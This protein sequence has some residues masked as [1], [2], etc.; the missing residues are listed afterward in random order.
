MSEQFK[1]CK[2]CQKEMTV[3]DDHSECFRHQTCNEAFPC[4]V[5]RKW[6]KEKRSII[7]KMIDKKIA[8][9]TAASTLTSTS[10]AVDKSPADPIDGISGQSRK[11]PARVSSVPTHSAIDGG[12]DRVRRS[13][14][15]P[16]IRTVTGI[17]NQ[18]KI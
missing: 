6:S 18:Q 17:S 3:L 1:L 9:M 5:C 10:N 14:I 12:G 7:N 16:L 2:T 15:E 11:S 8:Q 13:G 4:D